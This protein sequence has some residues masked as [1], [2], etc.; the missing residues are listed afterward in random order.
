[1]SAQTPAYP[2]HGSMGEVTHEGM[3]LRD[4]FAAQA[5]PAMMTEALKF[6]AS[7]ESIARDAY[8]FADCMLAA[9]EVKL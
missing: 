8:R 4:Y 5:L 6:K 7:P 1:M 2:S 9:R 3:T